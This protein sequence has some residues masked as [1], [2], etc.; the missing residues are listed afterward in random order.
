MPM[1]RCIVD[2]SILYIVYKEQALSKRSFERA[3]LLIDG[4]RNAVIFIIFGYFKYLGDRMLFQV[5][6]YFKE[7]LS[8][9]NLGKNFFT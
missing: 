8:F 9:K 4:Y 7:G 2:E 6:P 1:Q 3:A 5:N